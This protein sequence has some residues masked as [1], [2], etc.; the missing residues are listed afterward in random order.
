MREGL[1]PKKILVICE[2]EKKMTWLVKSSNIKRE[3]IIIDQDSK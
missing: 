1:R 3:T 2:N